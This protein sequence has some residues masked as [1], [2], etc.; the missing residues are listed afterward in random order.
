MRT[1]P[2]RELR[3]VRR[4]FVLSSIKITTLILL[5]TE[6]KKGKADPGTNISQLMQLKQLKNCTIHDQV[7]G[8]I[9]MPREHG[10][11]SAVCF[12]EN[13]LES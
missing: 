4:R 5:Y 7:A 6:E 2:L 1:L 3:W 11:S 12:K 10:R 13:I 8:F 9:S